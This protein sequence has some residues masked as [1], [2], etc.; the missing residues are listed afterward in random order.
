MINYTNTFYD[1]YI[2]FNPDK[3]PIG[4]VILLHG[5]G[6]DGNDFVPMVSKLNLPD[7]L[8]LRFIF[9]HAPTR[10]ITINNGYR[11]RAWFDIYSLDSNHPIDHEGIIK[12]D[13]LLEQYIKKENDLSIPSANI[14]LAGF[15]QGAVIALTTGLRYVEKLAGIIALSGYLPDASKILTGASQNNKSTPIFVGHGNEDN[16]ISVRYGEKTAQLLKKEGYPVDWH[17]YNMT[18]SMCS[19]EIYDIRQWLM[20]TFNV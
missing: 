19:D 12:S 8:A 10:P 14:V 9:P 3:K 13:Q 15:S 7:D 4:S 1:H 11:M 17:A 5:L 6:A 18:H 2:E 20:R 16:L